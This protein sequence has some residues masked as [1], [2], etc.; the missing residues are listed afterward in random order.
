M[1]CFSG[2]GLKAGLMLLLCS[3]LGAVSANALADEPEYGE[4]AAAIRSANYPCAHVIHVS[5]VS[6]KS[7]NV[8]CNSGHFRVTRDEEGD[9]TVTKAD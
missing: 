4:M 9:Y 2:A 3:V 5:S 1:G 7:W 6:S 8:E